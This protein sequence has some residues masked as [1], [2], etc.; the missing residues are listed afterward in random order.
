MRSWIDSPF[1]RAILSISLY[2][3][4]GIGMYVSTIISVSMFALTSFL[5]LILSVNRKSDFVFHI[6][7]R[8]HVYHPLKISEPRHISACILS[9]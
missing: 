1:L 9:I 5:S 7:H 3:G 8:A 2:S 6:F 4:S